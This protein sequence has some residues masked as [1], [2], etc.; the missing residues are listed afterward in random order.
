MAVLRALVTL[1]E[2]SKLLDQTKLES[3]WGTQVKSARSAV[4]LA[5]M[6][7]HC[8]VMPVRKKDNAGEKVNISFAIKSTR[9]ELEAA[10]AMGREADGRQWHAQGGA[11]IPRAP[12]A[13]GPGAA[14]GAGGQG[15]RWGST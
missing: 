14:V 15:R 2:Q 11:R 6:V 5:E 12:G 7:L 10:L 1:C 3:F 13:P 8:R 9:P 4:D